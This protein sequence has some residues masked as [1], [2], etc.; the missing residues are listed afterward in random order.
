MDVAI[1]GAGGHDVT[2]SS[3]GFSAWADHN[4]NPVSDVGIASLADGND[5]SVS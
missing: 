1:D 2:L 3:N 5:P 4:V